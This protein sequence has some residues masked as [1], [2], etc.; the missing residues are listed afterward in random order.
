MYGVVYILI[1]RNSP[2]VT[3][4]L[5]SLTILHIPAVPLSAALISNKEGEERRK[6]GG[7]SKTH[8]LKFTATLLLPL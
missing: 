8:E 7:W 6:V 2:Q 4:A 5:P 3:P 1:I